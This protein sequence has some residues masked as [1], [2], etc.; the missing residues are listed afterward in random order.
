MIDL[1]LTLAPPGLHL[2]SPLLQDVA[3]AYASSGRFYH[4]LSHVEAVAQQFAAVTPQW[5]SPREVYLALLYHDAVYVPGAADNEAR[6]ATRAKSAIGSFLPHARIDTG[7]VAELILATARH[8]SHPAGGADTDLA[9]FLDCDMSIL[10]AAPGTYDAYA[11]GVADE[12][13]WLPLDQYR[14]GRR[15][16]LEKLIAAPRIFLS[17][18][19]HASLDTAARANLAREVAAL[20]GAPAGE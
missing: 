11:R 15:H 16:F 20:G 17:D 7:R 19:F 8:G 14:A 18:R 13:A 6:S 9:L 10:G 4:G 12:Y 5:R 1:L 2:P 3:A